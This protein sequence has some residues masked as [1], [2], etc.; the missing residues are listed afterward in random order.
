MATKDPINWMLS[1][2]IETAA[3]RNCQ[4]KSEYIRRSVFDCLKADGIDP[5]R[6]AG[7]A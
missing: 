7:T 5:A 3:R 1:D 4:T 6:L 2:A